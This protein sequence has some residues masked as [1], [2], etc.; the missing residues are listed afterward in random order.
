MNSMNHWNHEALPYLITCSLFERILIRQN[1][2]TSDDRWSCLTNITHNS[3]GLVMP[4]N[5]VSLNRCQW[6]GSTEEEINVNRQKRQ[7]KTIIQ[8][9]IIYYLSPDISSRIEFRRQKFYFWTNKKVKNFIFHNYFY[10][11]VKY[12]DGNTVQYCEQFV[13]KWE[14]RVFFS[15]FAISWHWICCSTKG[16]KKKISK[17]KREKK[18]N[19][20]IERKRDNKMQKR[21]KKT[22]ENGESV[23]I[24]F[25]GGQAGRTYPMKSLIKW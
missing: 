8:F 11:L 25:A 7:Q 1:Q 12:G 18:K 21:K 9:Q 10:T 6:N 19:M 16:I 2:V 4:S 13:I 24:E 5:T 3:V 20:K 14:I 23:K 22:I 17:E 15:K